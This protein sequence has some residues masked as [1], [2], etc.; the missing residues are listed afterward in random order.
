M[1]RR[2]FW[3]LID[4]IRAERPRLTVLVATAYMEEAERFDHVVAIDAGRV[5]AQGAT[6]ELLKRTGN[7]HFEEAYIALQRRQRRG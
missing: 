1:S 7:P 4:D 6:T 2:Q 3:R 5:L